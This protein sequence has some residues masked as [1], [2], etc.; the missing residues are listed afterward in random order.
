M[1]LKELTE[2]F[3]VSGAEEEVR[4]I[5]K[6]EIEGLAK[7]RTDALGNLFFEKPGKDKK[8]KIMLAAHMDEVGLMITSIGK[9]GWLK[10]D[11]VGGI[12][13]RILVSKTVLIGPKKVKGVI[14][15]KAIHLQEPK[16]RETALKSKNLYIDIGAKD[17]ED[18][19][20]KVKVGDYA[21][22]DSQFER[23]GDLIKAKA[24]DDRVG[25]YIITEILKKNYDLTIAG[26]FTV[27]EEIGLR[28][29]AVAAYAI[30]PDVAIVIEGTFAADV[31][32]NKEEGYSTTLDKGPAVTLMDKTY[33]A[34]RRLVDRVIQ[35][36]ERKGI[37]CQLRRTAFGG[38]DAGRIHTTKEGIPTIVISVPC[39][40]IHSPAGLAS[41]TDIQNT[42][43]LID[44]LI[45]DFQERGL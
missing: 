35:V 5:L 34:D 7:L 19:E 6:R 42:I 24:L 3:G 41:L 32:E 17:K 28:G 27:Q 16:E 15:A 45:I 39:R 37:P 12:D 20:K 40:Y 30:E 22:F 33:I 21:V 23:I 18:A 10:F 43:A 2:A 4:N 29:S 1:L 38:T 44:A 36:A 25:C 14:G 31:P 26:A 11:T 9:N 13:D 8:P